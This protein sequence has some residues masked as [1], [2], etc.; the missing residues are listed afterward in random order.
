M[1][2]TEAKFQ[3]ILAE[4][5]RFQATGRTA[6]QVIHRSL[7]ETNSDSCVHRNMPLCPIQ[8]QMYPVHLYLLVHFSI[9]LFSELFLQSCLLTSCFHNNVYAHPFYSVFPSTAAQPLST[10]TVMITVVCLIIYMYSFFRQLSL[11][12]RDLKPAILTPFMTPGYS[13]K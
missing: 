8:R 3:A 5:S 11:Y 9:T 7:L 10:A 12:S 1:E 2:S 13:P 6:R 4:V